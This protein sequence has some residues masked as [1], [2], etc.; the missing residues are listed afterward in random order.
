MFTIDE[1]VSLGAREVAELLG[2][3]PGCLESLMGPGNVAHIEVTPDW[4]NE[5]PFWAVPESAAVFVSRE[6]YLSGG[7]RSLPHVGDEFPA[8]LEAAFL[9]HARDEDKLKVLTRYARTQGYKVREC[10]LVG[11]SQ[12]DWVDLLIVERAEGDVD[13]STLNAWLAG[14]VFCVS[15]T[16]DSPLEG[17]WPEFPH[18]PTIVLGEW[19]ESCCGFYGEAAARAAALDMLA[20][21]VAHVRT[22][23]WDSLRVTQGGEF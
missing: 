23:V 20:V 14:D 10:G 3:S 7:V 22:Q 16:V 2:E 1:S 15:V 17:S 18:V 5:F 19:D 8:E 12:G 11:H 21:G 13:H 6:P 9:E 4:D